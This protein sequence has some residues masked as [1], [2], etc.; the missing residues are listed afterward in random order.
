[1]V[2]LEGSPPEPVHSRLLALAG[3]GRPVL[4]PHTRVRRSAF[5][6]TIVVLRGLGASFRLTKGAVIEQTLT[7]YHGSAPVKQTSIL[8][9]TT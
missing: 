8:G 2:P 6:I 7:I 4:H 3:A 9:C 5:L 1:M